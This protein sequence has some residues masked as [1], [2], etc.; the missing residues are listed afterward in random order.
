MIL[1]TYQNFILKSYFKNLLVIILIFSFLIF[2]LNI[3]EEIKFFNELNL[4]IFYPILLT[5]LNV[6]NL[7]FDLFPF[8][9]LIGTQF[10]F[11][12]LIEKE[13]LN[14]FKNF[15]L[16]NFKIFKILIF[17][18]FISG[19]LICT[20]YYNFSASM[21]HSYLSFKNKYSKDNKYLAVVN[22]NGLWIRDEIN[23]QINIISAQKF[24]F[25]ILEDITISQFDKKF[26]LVKTITAKN[27]NIDKKYWKLNNAI[28]FKDSQPPLEYKTKTFESNFNKEKV[29][30]LY[31]NL[32][33][34]N[35]FQLKNLYK[36]YKSLGYSTLN[37]ESH[38]HKIYSYPLYITI[39]TIIGGILMLN[40]NYKIN[41][42]F[43]FIIGVLFS[44]IIYYLYYF[45]NLLGTSERVPIVVASWMPIVILSLFCVMGIIKINEK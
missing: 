10:F 23:N 17:S 38:L 39:M 33:S 6:P 43:T 8:I 7:L 34:L 18:T 16:E 36:D 3:L 13:E 11:L 2:F 45:F 29:D 12:S 1:S 28:E 19:V 32:S 20:L 35:I 15:G 30:N 37:V 31:S 25:E 22:E 44:V 40:V 26:N 9:F 4:G 14:I 21:K 42:T 5:L 24:K 41:K 27:A